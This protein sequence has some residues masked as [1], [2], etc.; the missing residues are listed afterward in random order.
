MIAKAPRPPK[1]TTVST[2]P[3]ITFVRDFCHFALLS[4]PPVSLYVL[5]ELFMSFTLPARMMMPA[6]KKMPSRHGVGVV[7]KDHVF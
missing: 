6:I 3:T 4:A 2:L 5:N 1:D 7:V